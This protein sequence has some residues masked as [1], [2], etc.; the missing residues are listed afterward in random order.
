MD[1]DSAVSSPDSRIMIQIEQTIP[2][3]IRDANGC[4]A[5]KVRRNTSFAKLPEALIAEKAEPAIGVK[6]RRVRISVAVKI[7]VRES[8]Q[9]RYAFE[10]MQD[11]EGPIAV[12]PEHCRC[13][14]RVAEQ[15][16]EVA[17][18]IYV[19]GPGSAVGGSDHSCR[20]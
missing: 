6:K 16:I 10:R 2:I 9:P 3:G 4:H 13:S 18:K 15:N 5:P 1:I 11:C 14:I 12:V 19:G 7:G 8:S 17:I 20:H